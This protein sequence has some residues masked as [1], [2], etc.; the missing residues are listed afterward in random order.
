MEFKPPTRM[1]NSID[2]VKN[3]E[4]KLQTL[5][6]FH[7]NGTTVVLVPVEQAEAWIAFLG[8]L[9]T[10]TEKRQEEVKGKADGKRLRPK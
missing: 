9:A 1:L 5:P 7:M 2:M 3:M 8:Q 4:T 10:A 6:R